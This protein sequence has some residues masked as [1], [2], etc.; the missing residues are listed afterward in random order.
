MKKGLTLIE[1]LIVAAIVATLLAILVPSFEVY[2]QKQLRQREG[3]QSQLLTSPLIEI[4][5]CK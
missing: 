1:W 3:E 5:P 2:H 4:N